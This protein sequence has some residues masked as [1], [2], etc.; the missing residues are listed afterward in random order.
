[1]EQLQTDNEAD[2]M[3]TYA[4]ELEAMFDRVAS[5][6]SR[7]HHKAHALL[8]PDFEARLR[9]SLIAEIVPT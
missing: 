4:M 5:H 7:D 9:N 1:M 8:L 3:G 6:Y 2:V